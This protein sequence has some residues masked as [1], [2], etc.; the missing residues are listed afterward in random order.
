MR[1]SITDK[2]LWDV[3]DFLSSAGDVTGSIFRPYPTMRNSLPGI[4][5]PIFSKYRKE[6]GKREFSNLIYYLKRKG[7]IKIKNL[8]SKQAII[9]T[10]EGID[11]ALKASFKLDKGKKRKDGKWVMLIFDVPVKHKRARELLRS[12]LQNLGY[13]MFQ[14]SVWISPYDISGKT[15]KLIQMH[16]LDNYVKI[17][18][19]EEL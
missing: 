15:E 4:R 8:E 12:V 10:K 9:L 11:R 14:Q 13:K 19:I 2:F 16:S 3:Y 17:F 5:N 1:I 7:Y 6:K 18:L